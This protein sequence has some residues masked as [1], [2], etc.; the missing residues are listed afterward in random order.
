MIDKSEVLHNIKT[1]SDTDL[2]I[3]RINTKKGENFAK[4]KSRDKGLKF[5]YLTRTTGNSLKPTMEFIQSNELR[6]GGAESAPRP[7]NTSVDGSIDVELSPVTFDDN[8]CSL[9]NNEW[10]VWNSDAD[11]ASNL[12]K[13]PCDEGKFLT[14]ACKQAA[15]D[16]N[17]DDVVKGYLFNGVFYEEDSHTTE[18]TGEEDKIYVDLTE[19]EKPHYQWLGGKYEPK[20]DEDSYNNDETFRPR[21]LLNDGVAGHEDGILIVPKG[22]VVNEMTFGKKNIE[23]LIAKKY[24]GVEGEDMYHLFR[25]LAVNT[26]DL[27]AEIGQIVTGSFG[28]MGDASTDI[29]DEA[30]AK[31]NLG[32]ATP[33]KFEDGVTTGESFIDNLPE[34]ATDTDQFTAREGDL[35]INGKNITFGKTLTFNVDKN[36]E[37]KYALF[38]KN[39]ISKTS[40]KKAI[41]ANLNTYL[42]PD[43]KALY[44]LANNNKTFEVLFA[45]EDKGYMNDSF[46]DEDKPEFIYMVQIFNAKAE[47]KDLTASGE[48]D[49]DMSIPLRSFGERL[50]RVLKIALP[51]FISSE[52]LEVVADGD[53]PTGVKNA[54]SFTP[55]ILLGQGSLSL[56]DAST[57]P[58]GIKVSVK[59]DDVEQ[60]FTPVLGY[61]VPDTSDPDNPNKTKIVD[62]A[63]DVVTGANIILDLV[64]DGGVSDTYGQVTVLT[65]VA[66]TTAEQ[67]L[68]V[69]VSWNGKDCTN[70]FTI[71]ASV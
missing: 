30:E 51:K 18:I 25:R 71:P 54:V 44:N 20:L 13:V 58:K 69:T 50:C 3:A 41:T 22:S 21:R 49:Y 47:D 46:K 45:F 16:I 10:R 38:V 39:A 40:L 2:Y 12:D 11:S 56:Y 42:V 66:Q 23:Y 29:L 19:V 62:A 55:N 35:W 60:A 68:E 52:S 61:E 57:E 48:A 8:M 70:F 9:F 63:G 1:G 53:T 4:I 7:G 24:G 32:G 28:F 14:R 5:P 43:A 36:M 33:S 59:V 17:G 34:K 26:V 64:E 6:H 65:G 67:K 27:N 15:G 31:E 37:R